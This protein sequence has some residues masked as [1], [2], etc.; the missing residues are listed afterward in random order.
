MYLPQKTTHEL[1]EALHGA[2]LALG[3]TVSLDLVE[4]A[5]ART[6]VAKSFNRVSA[7]W[8]N[9]NHITIVSRCRKCTSALDSEGFCKNNQCDFHM[10]PQEVSSALIAVTE[11]HEVM[12]LNSYDV[13]VSDREKS[14]KSAAE[15]NRETQTL[16]LFQLARKSA[17]LAMLAEGCL[18]EAHE[19]ILFAAE[20]VMSKRGYGRCASSLLRVPIF[21]RSAFDRLSCQAE[22]ERKDRDGKPFLR[23]CLIF[24]S[25]GLRYRFIINKEVLSNLENIET[26]PFL[27]CPKW[28]STAFECI[29]PSSRPLISEIEAVVDAFEERVIEEAIESGC[30]P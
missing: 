29:P 6:L 10:W 26:T 19:K 16:K 25:V 27:G 7:D 30:A 5:V 2:F 15:P 3:V 8:N 9:N 23:F 12:S 13:F 14:Q 21:T 1:N 24:G 17:A 4:Q 22:F 28:A 18:E 11:Q 20:L